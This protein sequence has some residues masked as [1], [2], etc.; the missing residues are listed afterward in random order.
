[1]LDIWLGV[2]GLLY[3]NVLAVSCRFNPAEG[4]TT[5]T[6]R[7]TS[8]WTQLGGEACRASDESA[9]LTLITAL[10]TNMLRRN[11]AAGFSPGGAMS[12]R[13]GRS[14]GAVPC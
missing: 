3:A 14:R 5:P 6:R 13:V 8:I 12:H 4:A 9:L 7:H 10:G 1:M 11:S 2:E